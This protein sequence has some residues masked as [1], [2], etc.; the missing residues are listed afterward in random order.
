MSD[1]LRRK[2]QE[3]AAKEQQ[4]AQTPP[5]PSALAPDASPAVPPSQAPPPVAPAAATPA[6]AIPAAAAPAKPKG[7]PLKTS[8]SDYDIAYEHDRTVRKVFR[9]RV[10]Y[11]RNG[12]IGSS[13]CLLSDPYNFEV[14][15]QF[16]AILKGGEELPGAKGVFVKV[17]ET[18]EPHLVLNA[19]KTCTPRVI[20]VIDLETGKRIAP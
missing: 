3:Q 8:R 17:I 9:L 1:Y 15:E 13:H 5:S 11:N 10:V 19:A 6:V 18:E 4:G 12:C 14:D 16:K 20:S 2:L 7:G